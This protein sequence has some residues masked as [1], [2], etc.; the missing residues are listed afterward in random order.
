MTLS[1]VFAGLFFVWEFSDFHLIIYIINQLMQSQKLLQI[2]FLLNVV[3]NVVVCYCP[4]FQS[5]FQVK[6]S[7]N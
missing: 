2:N 1:I 5:K 4:V 6:A 3:D 7:G